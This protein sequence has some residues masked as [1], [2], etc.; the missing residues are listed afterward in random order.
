MHYIGA[1]VNKL[2]PDGKTM[3]LDVSADDD[4][5][6][7]PPA[8]D[9]PD[10]ARHDGVRGMTADRRRTAAVAVAVF[11]AVTAIGLLVGAPAIG[12][13]AGLVLAILTVLL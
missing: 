12:L 8:L 9:G 5:G 7:H 2:D 11:A 13:L 4:Q 6:R 1:K 3:Y 10:H